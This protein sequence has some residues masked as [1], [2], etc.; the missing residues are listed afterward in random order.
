MDASCGAFTQVFSRS[1]STAPPKNVMQSLLS[2]D[3]LGRTYVN[4]FLLAS[5]PPT[6]TATMIDRAFQAGWGGAVTKTIPASPPPIDVQPRFAPVKHHGHHIGF[7]NIE[8]ISHRPLD[9]WIDELVALKTNWSNRAVWVSIMAGM[10]KNDWQRLTLAIQKTGIDVIEL[11]VSCP[12]GMP[13]QGMGALIGQSAELTAEVVH[14]VKAVADV[15]VVV[16]LTPNVTDITVIANAA[17]DAGADGFCAINTVS[18]ISGVDLLTLSPQPAIDGF[19]CEGGISGP[20]IRPTAL[21]AVANVARVTGLPVSGCG[22]ISTW[23]NAVEFLALGSGTVQ[24]CTEPMR[25]GIGMI[26]MLIEGIERWLK[27]RNITTLADIVGV[28]LNRVVKHEDL[29]RH[30]RFRPSIPQTCTGCG[31][32]V[33]ACF[34]AGFQ[35]LSLAHSRVSIDESLCNGCGLCSIVCPLR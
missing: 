9:I 34:D 7:Q 6:K 5:G 4:P 15:P 25:Q 19:S 27:E 3:F 21:R 22:G 33:T 8:V 14:W 26:S 16:K 10:V 17:K 35:S 2:F 24:L 29:S 32:C 30:Y 12:N 1:I 20:A 11:N 23:E 31:K 13:D 28:A 18:G